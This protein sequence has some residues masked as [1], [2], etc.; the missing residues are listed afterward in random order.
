MFLTFP[1]GSMNSNNKRMRDTETSSEYPNK[2]H[3]NI[4]TESSLQSNDTVSIPPSDVVL[5]TNSTNNLID[6]QPVISDIT[7]LRRPCNNIDSQLPP[8]S[9]AKLTNSDLCQQPTS[10]VIHSI[11]IS[12][13]IHTAV[14][15]KLSPDQKRT[16]AFGTFIVTLTHETNNDYV[17]IIITCDNLTKQL[18]NTTDLCK[19]PYTHKSN[20]FI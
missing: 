6:K 2:S 20:I 11:I 7:P 10:C 4:H 19:F 8:S 3:K 17:K 5:N 12:H 16:V 9:H 15:V 14:V 1:R 13:P 18:N